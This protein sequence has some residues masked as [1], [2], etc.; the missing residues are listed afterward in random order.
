MNGNKCTILMYEIL[1]IRKTGYKVYRN[2]VSTFFVKL[3]LF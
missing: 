2:S 3:K 1:T